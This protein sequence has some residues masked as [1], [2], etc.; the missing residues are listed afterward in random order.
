MKLD[1]C[2][3]CSR[4]AKLAEFGYLIYKTATSLIIL[5]K[6]QYHRGQCIVAYR[7]DHIANMID[8]DEKERSLFIKDVV[9]A[10]KCIQK[11]YHPAKINYCA[12]EDQIGHLHFH[13]VPKYEGQD[14]N[15]CLMNHSS[16]NMIDEV[17]CETIAN[18]IRQAY[19]NIK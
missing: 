6:D 3:Y 15:E 17:E 1:D 14:D 16:R 12:I 11:I 2:P 9:D 5:N 7:N 19:E 8:L 13:I 10:A 4:G 18:K